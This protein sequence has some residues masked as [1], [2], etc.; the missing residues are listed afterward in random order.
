MQFVSVKIEVVK[1]FES[2][3]EANSFIESYHNNV[4]ETIVINNQKE[5]TNLESLESFDVVEAILH[6]EEDDISI[7]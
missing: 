3:E 6:T 4:S 2:I 1:N 5:K 7:I